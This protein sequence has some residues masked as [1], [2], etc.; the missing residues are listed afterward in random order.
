[1]D[2]LNI[3]A[4][5]SLNASNDSRAEN[6]LIAQAVGQTW[7]S[8]AA[9]L[10]GLGGTDPF[11]YLMSHESKFIEDS[12]YNTLQDN[13][14]LTRRRQILQFYKDRHD[15]MEM[16]IPRGIPRIMDYGT[17]VFLP[18]IPH[19]QLEAQYQCLKAK[20]PTLT[21][22]VPTYSTPITLGKLKF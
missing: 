8:P 7:W 2:I 16:P 17:N 18:N 12:Y 11:P 3:S 21:W 22:S 20:L 13:E 5:I 1:M 9:H 14:S 6:E 4:Q 10:E 15:G 19:H